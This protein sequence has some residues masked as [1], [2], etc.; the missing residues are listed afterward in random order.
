MAMPGDSAPGQSESPIAAVVSGMRERMDRIPARLSHQRVFLSNYQRTTQAVGEA[1]ERAS[2]QDPGW[3]E[4]WD[5]AFAGLYLTALDAELA[6]GGHVPRPWRMA[7]AASP[8]LPPLSHVL[9][10]INA[11]VNYDLPQA[12]PAVISEFPLSFP[13]PGPRTPCRSG[14]SLSR[15][16]ASPVS[17]HRP[18]R[19]SWGW[20]KR[21]FETQDW[22]LVK[23]CPI[24]IPNRH[25]LP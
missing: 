18:R 25:S 22:T 14:C 10:G 9:L 6:G 1:V 11:H 17:G 15:E 13:S 16:H 20:A 19:S 7:F 8:D 21:P 24:V 4:S 5:V 12:L 2:F 3:V 23:F